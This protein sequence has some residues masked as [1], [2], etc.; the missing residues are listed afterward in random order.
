MITDKQLTE[1]SYKMSEAFEEINTKYIELMSK[2]IRD[3]GKLSATDMHR[4]Q[5]MARMNANIDEIN[6]LIRKQCNLTLAELHKVYL[7]SGLSVYKDAKIFYD[8]KG[9]VQVPFAKN[10]RIQQ[11][12][13]S[14]EQLTANTF[15]NLSRTTV[16]SK[17]YQKVVDKSIYAV[18]SGLEDYQSAIRRA[19]VKAA[20]DGMRVRYASGVTRRLDSAVRMNVLSGVRQV[21]LGTRMI[22]GEQYGADGYEISAHGLCA[23]DHLDIQGRQ[24]T[25]KQFN[26]LQNSLKR[27]IG[28][29]N[30]QHTAYPIVMGISSPAHTPE[31][32]QY[33]NEYSTEK[34]DLGNGKQVTRY[35]ASQLMR[36]IE[37]NIRY[38]KDAYIAG[39]ASGDDVIVNNA[40][41]KIKRNK[42]L[43]S[44]IAD[45]A[46]LQKRPERMR[47]P[48]YTGR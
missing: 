10:M 41:A 27:P 6:K 34:I 1:I 31:E 13:K 16:L 18:S 46:G 25:L 21:N 7:A 36:N 5:Q 19:L 39:K 37:T 28:E 43:Y 11:Y 17:N 20:T 35:E 4:L 9:A 45:K 32:L 2:H 42:E 22:T 47:V 14:I 8:A 29:L 15:E 44:S 3:M 30:C 26:N 48:G 12:I 38:G 40:K 24:F 23:E 33:M